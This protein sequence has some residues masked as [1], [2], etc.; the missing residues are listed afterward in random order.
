MSGIVK[1]VVMLGLSTALSSAAAAGQAEAR[2]ARAVFEANTCDSCHAVAKRSTGPALREIAA[3]YRGK[4][5]EQAVADRIR[6]G[7]Q[8]HW[9][10]AVHPSYEAMD[11][12]DAELLARWILGGAPR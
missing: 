7:S 11:A 8:G 1:M 3:R 5:A 6:A 2:A 10:S 12:R 9:G 4:R